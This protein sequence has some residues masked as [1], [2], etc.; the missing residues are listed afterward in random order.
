MNSRRLMSPGTYSSKISQSAGGKSLAFLRSIVSWTSIWI[1]SLVG[2]EVKKNITAL[3]G[4]SLDVN[5]RNGVTD[6]EILNF[7]LK[8]NS[9][10]VTQ[11][12]FNCNPNLKNDI[13]HTRS[14]IT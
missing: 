13:A 7:S 11:F 2:C 3:F 8:T 1:D 10:S 12:R 9:V 6:T 5:V 14:T 4:R